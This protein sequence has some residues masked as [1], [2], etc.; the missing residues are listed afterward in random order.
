MRIYATTEGREYD[1]EQL[2]D[3][4]R[5]YVQQALRWYQ[6]G[7]L[8]TEFLSRILGKGSPVW[9]RRR[10]YRSPVD[11][12][13]YDI[14]TDLEGRLAVKQGHL[15]KDWEGA[16]DPEGLASGQAGNTDSKGFAP[17]D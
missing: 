8:F 5:A 3:G 16:V 7:M 14:L 1:L 4:D 10:G 17:N 13:L 11:T 9:Q 2:P 6:Q 12:P 15:A